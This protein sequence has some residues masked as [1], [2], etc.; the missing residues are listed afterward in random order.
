MV[1]ALSGG[2]ILTSSRPRCGMIGAFNRLRRGESPRIHQLFLKPALML[3]LM[4]PC[5]VSPTEP[6]MVTPSITFCS[7]PTLRCHLSSVDDSVWPAV[8][9]VPVSPIETFAD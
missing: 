9:L 8:M 6:E 4:V 5:G 3:L 7:A 1:T 2:P